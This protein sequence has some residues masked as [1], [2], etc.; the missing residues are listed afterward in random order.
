MMRGFNGNE[1]RIYGLSSLTIGDL[2][3]LFEK[4]GYPD[5]KQRAR[6]A[7]FSP[8]KSNDASMLGQHIFTHD[9]ARTREEA[10]AMAA[11]VIAMCED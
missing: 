3:T 1:L 8:F 2:E 5:A 7:K 11:D 6:V 4:Y 9:L 10:D